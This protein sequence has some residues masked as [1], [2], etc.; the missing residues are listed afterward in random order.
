M[1]KIF[2]MMGKSACGKDKLFSLLSD[3]PEIGLRRLVLYTTR[4][5]RRNETE[6]VQYHFVTDEALA[7]LEKEGRVIEKR[8]YETVAGPWTYATVD[9]GTLDSGEMSLITI[10]TLESYMKIREYLGEGKVIPLYIETED[11]IRLARALRREGKQEEPN[12][13]E[14]CRRF[15]SDCEDFSEEKIAEAGIEKRFEN[16]GELS[17]VLSA[18][19]TYIMNVIISSNGNHEI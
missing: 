12:Y 10:G 11:G 5:I 3:D 16:N 18:L 17:D 1:G 2:Y 14:V 9:D 4:P 19:K 6:G 13:R 8:V 7:A 15:L